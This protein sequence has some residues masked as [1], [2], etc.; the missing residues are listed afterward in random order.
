MAEKNEK[1]VLITIDN[2]RVKEYDSMNVV[3]ERYEEVFNPIS[4]ETIRKWRFKGYSKDILSALQFIQSNEL[5]IDKKAIS[6]LKSHL[7]Q[8]YESNAKLL[9]VMKT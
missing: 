2:V 4:K 9:E 5:L 3:V 8:V 1:K 7:K 6:D